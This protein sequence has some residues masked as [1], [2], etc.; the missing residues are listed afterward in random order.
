MRLGDGLFVILL[1]F[2]GAACRRDLQRSGAPSPS[3]IPTP[4][5][6]RSAAATLRLV[7]CGWGSVSQ[8]PGIDSPPWL[9]AIVD[10]EAHRPISG[11]AVLG[12]ELYADQKRITKIGG[13]PG[14]RIQ[15]GPPNDSLGAADTQDLQGGALPIGLHRLRVATRLEGQLADL[16]GR[17]PNRC[18]LVLADESSQ[19]LV[20][21][22]TLEPVWEVH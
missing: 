11:L 14:I 2:T 12:A 9:I 10:V 3:E 20:V 7:R 13:T 6:R 22:G 1:A 15:E 5:A 19:S 21:D 8:G 4:N 16:Q 18:R 17:H